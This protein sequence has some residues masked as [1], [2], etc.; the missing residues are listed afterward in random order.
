MLIT[1][2]FFIFLACILYS[3]GVWAEKIQGRLKSWHAVV[4]W[5][6][7]TADTIGTGAMGILAGSL[8][9]FN[10]HGLTGLLAI[11]L[12]LFHA[13][14]AT[15]VLVRKNEN[16]ILKFHR[17]SLLVWIIWLIPMVSGMILGSGV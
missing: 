6:G 15:A 8:F 12:M 4:F 1:A 14:W 5:A 3:L 9:Q 2:I 17:F 7:L 13:A 10:F 11:M 16:M